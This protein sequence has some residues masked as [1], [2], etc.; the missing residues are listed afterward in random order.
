MLGRPLVFSGGESF[1]M[2]VRRL[3]VIKSET[4]HLFLSFF[5]FLSFRYQQ[6]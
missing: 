5:F 3:P 6:T 4:F 2:T 1:F